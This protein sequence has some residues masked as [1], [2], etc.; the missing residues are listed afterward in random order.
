MTAVGQPTAPPSLPKSEPQ[1]CSVLP[2]WRGITCITLRRADLRLRGPADRCDVNLIGP[3][4]PAGTHA[5]QKQ[6]H[7]GQEETTDEGGVED[8]CG[9]KSEPEL[10]DEQE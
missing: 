2:G 1:T 8:D 7:G 4:R 6:Y 10:L 9:G 5:G 3:H